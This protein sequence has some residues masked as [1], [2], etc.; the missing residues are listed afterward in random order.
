[1]RAGSIIL[2]LS[3]LMIA[4]P[5]LAAGAPAWAKLSPEARSALAPLAQS[6]DNM[7][8]QQR[9]KLI[10][11]ARAYPGLSP[12]QQRLLHSRLRAWS[13]MT[14]EER[15]IARDNYKKIQALPEADQGRIRQQWLDSLCQEFGR[16]GSGQPPASP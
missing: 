10:N 7:P 2:A 1:M 5:G 12:Q 15:Q 16:P 3:L 13:G 8:S 6:W 11:V 14:R 9:E 4:A